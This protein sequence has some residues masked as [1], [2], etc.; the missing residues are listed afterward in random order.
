MEH[1]NVTTAP[2]K[3]GEPL[4]EQFAK[5]WAKLA[6]LVEKEGSARVVFGEDLV[7]ELY[8]DKN[9]YHWRDTKSRP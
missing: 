6:D 1:G 7:L 8:L 2:S 5:W 3:T 4:K 9:G